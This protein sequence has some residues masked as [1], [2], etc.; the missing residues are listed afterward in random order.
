PLGGFVGLRTWLG[1]PFVHA[2][3]KQVVVAGATRRPV[4]LDEFFLHPRQHVVIKCALHNEKWH[5]RY[6][7][8]A[9]ENFL[10][11]GLVDRLPRRE[12]HLVVFHHAL[13]VATQGVFV[14]RKGFADRR[15]GG[16]V[17]DC[18]VEVGRNGKRQ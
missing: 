8:F 10:R 11:V 9:I 14:A 12:E 7:F 15:A 13:V 4:R 16:N 5:R 1:Y 17:A 3:F 2:V 6:F 18:G